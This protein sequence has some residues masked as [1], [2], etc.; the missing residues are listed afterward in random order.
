MCGSQMDQNITRILL[1]LNDLLMLYQ[2]FC[3]NL[4][5]NRCG[6]FVAGGACTSI[7][8]CASIRIYSTIQNLNFGRYKRTALLDA[9][10]SPVHFFPVHRPP[11]LTDGF[12]SATDSPCP[13]PTKHGQPRLCQSSSAPPTHVWQGQRSRQSCI[14]P[15]ETLRSP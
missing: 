12:P 15:R 4:S 11:G 6:M 8:Y 9:N 7:R 5:F 14:C 13:T 2:A 10:M 1:F 3:V